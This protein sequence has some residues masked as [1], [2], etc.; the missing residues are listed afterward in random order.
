MNTTDWI[1]T[2]LGVYG[3]VITM[4]LIDSNKRCNK[5]YKIALE[6]IDKLSQRRKE[7]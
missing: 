3:Y 2:A 5:I 4:A 6:L 1:I 7:G